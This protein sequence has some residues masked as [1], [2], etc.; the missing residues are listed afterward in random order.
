[1]WN[2]C[3]AT[4][5]LVRANYELTHTATQEAVI[6]H[7]TNFAKVG[8][9]DELRAAIGSQMHLEDINDAIVALEIIEKR[10]SSTVPI[11]NLP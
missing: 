10:L 4:I 5:N 6:Q 2:K 9:E 1:M 3:T 7:L 11:T 8:S